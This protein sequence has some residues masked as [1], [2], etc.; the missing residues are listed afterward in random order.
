MTAV[1]INSPTDWESDHDTFAVCLCS[2]SAHHQ[3]RLLR[4]SGY[5]WPGH[6]SMKPE[7]R[8]Q[9]LRI[10]L[11]SKAYVNSITQLSY[12]PAFRPARFVA[13]VGFRCHPHAKRD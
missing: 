8:L 9:R 2:I 13:S 1:L 12:L 4:L 7:C 11:A 6:C 3:S 10:M 5:I